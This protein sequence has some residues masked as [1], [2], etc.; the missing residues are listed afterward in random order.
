MS[1]QECIPVGC[2]PS[3]AVVVFLVGGVRPAGCLGGCLPGGS[4]CL[5]GVYPG[6]VYLGVSSQGRGVHPLWTE[7]LTHSCENITFPQLRLRVVITYNDYRY[8][9]S[10]I[11]RFEQLEPVNVAVFVS[12]LTL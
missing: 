4:V 3:A 8:S 1:Q 11:L 2:V 9:H 5:G 10:L 7:F 12:F 6:V